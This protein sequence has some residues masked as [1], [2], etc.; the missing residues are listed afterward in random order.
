MDFLR[1]KALI[2]LLLMFILFIFIIV[3][4]PEKEK[5]CDELISEIPK[6][7]EQ[8]K[9]ARAFYVSNVIDGDTIVLDNGKKVRLLGINAPEKDMPFY[10]S[11][12]NFTKNL[13]LGKKVY[14]VR[15][16]SDKDLY[17]R[18]LRYVF[19]EDVFVNAELL[20]QGLA[21]LFI[22]EPNTKYAKL[23]SCLEEYARQNKLS[24][25]SKTKHY[26]LNI[27]VNFD[28]P[29]SDSENLNGEFVQIWNFGTEPI[30]LTGWIIK[31]AA[32]HIYK[33]ENFVLLPNKKVTIYTGFG[34]DSDE[35]LYWNSEAPIWNNDGD[36][37]YLFDNEGNLVA[38]LTFP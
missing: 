8:A 32:K 10:D 1:K 6:L 17:G 23:F 25:W 11:A 36:T 35:E 16:S 38:W 26:S 24:I 15:D 18:S 29:G 13:T 14:L 21:T 37:A 5:S 9:A 12:K 7:I 2:F 34:N 28:A 19:T 20:K 31:D 30:N 27:T 33:F 3:L 22:V 4:I